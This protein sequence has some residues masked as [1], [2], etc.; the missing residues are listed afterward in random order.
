MTTVTEIEGVGTAYAE[1][2]E[3]SGVHSAESLLDRGATP[4]GRK[5]IAEK[6]GISEQLIL[7]W[8]NHVDL[9]RI[10]GVAGEYAELLEASGVD[11]VPELAQRNAA[12]L[13]T[14]MLELNEEKHLVRR[15]PT[16]T[17]VHG[18]I[19]EARTLPRQVSY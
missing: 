18:W 6:T 15:V 3:A 11:T 8:V 14:K 12:N 1:K 7:K 10:K 13:H 9:F 17:E 4:Q 19:D 16:E 2:L 5:G